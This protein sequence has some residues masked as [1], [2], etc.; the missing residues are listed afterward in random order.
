MTLME[1][2]QYL[3]TKRISSLASLCRHFGAD[4]EMLRQMLLHW[5]RKGCVRRCAKTPACGVKCGKCEVSTTEIYE[6]IATC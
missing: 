3:M 2:K 5:E 6:W 1:I 4:A